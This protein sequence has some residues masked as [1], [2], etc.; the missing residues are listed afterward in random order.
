[1]AEP[2]TDRDLLRE[3]VQRG[4]EPAFQ[5]LVERHVNLVYGTAFRK[6]SD[7]AAAQEVTQSVFIALARKGA[8]LQGEVT[9]A[10]WLY[11]TALLE[12]RQWW[13]GEM[14]RQRR[15]QSAVEL[16]T[17]MKEE[18]SLLRS[19]TGVLD[20]GLMELKE[21]E[22][23]ALMLRFFEERSHREIGELLGTGEDA[24]RKRIDKGLEKLTQFFRRRGYAALAVATTAAA[25]KAAAQTAPAGL[26]TV[27]TKAA[28]TAG[29]AV[30]VTWLGLLWGTIMGLT[31]TQTVVI[32]AALV[33]VPV[34]YESHGL[35]R[36]RGEQANLELRLAQSGQDL[37]K[38]EKAQGDLQ[39]KLERS[40]Q[41]VET[42]RK[43]IERQRTA[44]A[45]M[46]TNY[47][48]WSE[49]SDYVRVPKTMIQKLD[50]TEVRERKLP[51]GATLTDRIPL[52][53]KDGTLSPV[54]EEVLGMTPAESVQ[55]K[56]VFQNAA[57]QFYGLV[58]THM[59]E[60]NKPKGYDAG[61]PHSRTFLI[62]AF[63]QEGAALRDTLQGNWRSALG[64][65]RADVLWEQAKDLLMKNSEDFGAK[66]KFVT[67]FWDDQGQNIGYGGATRSADGKSTEGS[68]VT[69]GPR[70]YVTEQMPEYL[71]PYLP[72]QANEQT[73]QPTN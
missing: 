52:I 42:L 11:Q 27:A 61:M 64:N 41:T 56:A 37:T 24:A 72:A 5:A 62:G 23:Q 63:P 50:L 18:E 12:A 31:K 21:A 60:T 53:D 16:G 43:E 14:R 33:A 40:G 35:M 29:G 59:T 15:E 28:L 30:S 7:V 44:A 68:F 55:V 36:A 39:K 17:T 54:M 45:K 47:Y 4:S 6:L 71:K 32:C 20:D 66:S 25:L 13:R 3:Y 26:T 58:Q 70:D 38:T 67:L 19:M 69:S 48:V 57:M 46:K 1:M 65:D 73:G 8:K 49:R 22:R 10:G 9:L 51:S 34:A 2:M